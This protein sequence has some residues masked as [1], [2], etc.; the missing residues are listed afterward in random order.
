MII[1]NE[2]GDARVR[3]GGGDGEVAVGFPPCLCE[4]EMIIW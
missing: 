1:G 2:V 3:H 4:D